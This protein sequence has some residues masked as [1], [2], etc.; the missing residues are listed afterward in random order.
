M[1]CI[2]VLFLIQS[3]FAFGQLEFVGMFGEKGNNNTNFD[4]PAGIA[5]D[6]QGKIYVADFANQR[7]QVWDFFGNFDSSISVEGLAHGVEI[8]KDEIYVAVWGNPHIE[9]FAKNGNKIKSF[10]GPEKPGDIAINGNGD[11]YVTSYGTGIIQI[12]DQTGN[13]VKTIQSAHNGISARLTGITLDTL[14]N[15]YVTD[16]INDRVM[17]L[18]SAGNFLFEF[19]VPPNEGGKFLRPTNVEINSNED[20][21]ITDNSGRIL[22]FDTAGNFLFSYGVLGEDKEQLNAPHGITFDES[23]Y[24][25][26]A[27]FNNNRIQIFKLISSF[28]ENQNTDSFEIDSKTDLKLEYIYFTIIIIILVTLGGIWIVFKREKFQA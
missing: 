25:Y 5:L 2:F 27:E 14:E 8:S 21:Y 13:K 6:S 11:I 24:V 10:P 28:D 7:I 15:I 22:V 16:Y 23:G 18:D 9:I 3:D 26:V 4:S 1:G 19:L 17:K 20:V 12:F